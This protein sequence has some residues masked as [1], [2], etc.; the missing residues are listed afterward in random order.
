MKTFP[1]TSLLCPEHSINIVRFCHAALRMTAWLFLSTNFYPPPFI[2]RKSEIF[3]NIFLTGA[4][5]LRQTHLFFVKKSR[6]L[7]YYASR[8]PPSPILEKSI[9]ISRSEDNTMVI[10]Y[11]FLDNTT[12]EVEVDD[13]LGNM[14]CKGLQGDKVAL[15]QPNPIRQA[16]VPRLPYR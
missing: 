1:G 8:A 2:Q 16:K 15:Y 5:A 9:L 6:Y 12:S 10:K 14:D 13:E 11:K 4:F 7:T 3:F